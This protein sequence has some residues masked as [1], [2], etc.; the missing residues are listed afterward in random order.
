M[1]RKGSRYTTQEK[2]NCIQLLEEGISLSAVSKDS[3]IKREQIR[4]WLDRYQ[5]FGVAGL[6]RSKVQRYPVAL[7]KEIVLKYLQGNTSYSQLAKEYQI[8]NYGIIYQWVT[9]YTSGKSLETTRR[10]TTMKDGR[11]TTKLERIEIAQWVIANDMDYVGA[12]RQ[13]NVSY[14]QA[15]AWVKKFNQGGPDALEDRRGKD[16]EDNGQLTENEKLVLENKRLK[17]RLERLATENALAKKIQE[18]ERRNALKKS[19]T[20]PSKHSPKK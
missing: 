18:L 20:K 19:H 13:F 2:L 14:G 5:R 7:K 15:Y 17:A 3:G 11:K 8:P 4:Q 16:K 6:K 12:T 1:G 9:R 10:S